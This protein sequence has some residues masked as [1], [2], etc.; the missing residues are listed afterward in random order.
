MFIEKEDVSLYVEVRGEGE[1]L[2]LIHGVI[3]D[4]GLY[5]KTAQILSGFYKVI[6]Y[7]RRGNSRSKLKENADP[8]FSM[9]AQADDIRDIL[10]ALDI[11][12]TYI[13]GA[14]GGGAVGEYF[15]R[16]YPERVLHL[17]MY[18]PS[19]L[20]M[21]IAEEKETAAWAEETQRLIKKKKFNNVLLRFSESIGAPDSRSPQKSE[22]E[23]MRQYE[24]IEY[25]FTVEFPGLVKNSPDIEKMK[26]MKDRIT[27]A[28]GEKS[29]DSKY[30]RI[31]RMLAE[32]TG[33][34]LVYYP[35]GHNLPYDLP[36][37]FAI[38]VIGTLI[39]QI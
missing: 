29:R 15:L 39:L 1:A 6:T 31:A 20:G 23:S 17:I 5:E 2:L 9:D 34:R 25:A 16:K 11:E 35:G 3:V 30:V 24:N 33:C 21:L 19:A 38:S 22:E 27:L 26:E 8:Y 12:K 36:T 28:A 4:A 13:A 32:R 10:D 18:E 14:S 37:E 7:D